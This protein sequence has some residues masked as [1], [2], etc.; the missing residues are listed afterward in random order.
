MTRDLILNRGDKVYVLKNKVDLILKLLE[1]LGAMGS[2]IFFNSLSTPLLVSEKMPEGRK[3]DVLFWQEG[4]RDDIPGNMQLILSGKSRRTRAVYVQKKASYEKLVRLGASREV[5]SPLGFV[6]GHVRENTFRN[7][8]L[9]CTNSDRIEKC[10]ELI[11]LLPKMHFYIAALTEMSSKL[12][13]LSRYDNV[14]L[15]PGART[16]FIDGL[17]DT[18]DYYL[19][20]NHGSEIVSAV[21]QAF[22]HN[23][24]ILGFKNTLH[25]RQFVPEGHVFDSHEALAAFLNQVM[26]REEMIREQIDLQKK[27]AMSEEAAMYTALLK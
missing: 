2:R 13:S 18:C 26:G 21:K 9:I 5:L 7:Q 11:R 4:V 24:L 25:N 14:T 6:Y 16:G 1:E 10:E 12:L 3:E 17:F 22:L 27:E 15:Y 19:D 23:Q 20:I 8:A